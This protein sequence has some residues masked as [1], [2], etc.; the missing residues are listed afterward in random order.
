MNIHDAI[1]SRR[2]VRSF[3]EQPVVVETIREI[4]DAARWAPSG[5]NTQP[6]EVQVVRGRTRQ[7]ICDALTQARKANEPERPG[8]RYYPEEWF[9]PYSGRKTA[10]GVSM[11]RAL[12]ITRKTP[13]SRQ[14]AWNRNYAFFGA[15]AFFPY[16]KSSP[17]GPGSTTACSS[18]TSASRRAAM[19]ST[20]ASRLPPPIIPTSS[21]RLSA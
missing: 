7:R 5:A 3:L 13:G 2:S 20:P 15:P 1:T 18:R 21:A 12:G 6:W 4:L 19:G 16:T 11:Y 8:Y 9:E 17:S 14:E 10:C